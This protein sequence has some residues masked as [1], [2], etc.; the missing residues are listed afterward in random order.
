MRLLTAISLALIVLM[1]LACTAT[2]ATPAPTPAPTPDVPLL[3]DY[4][5]D[6]LVRSYIVAQRH[7]TGDS[8]PCH[9]TLNVYDQLRDSMAEQLALYVGNDIWVVRF[10]HSRKYNSCIF[11][12]HDKEAHVILPK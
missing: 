7:I 3:D 6:G 11:T 9:T 5:V 4:T 2:P 1:A 12:V 10:P 8:Y